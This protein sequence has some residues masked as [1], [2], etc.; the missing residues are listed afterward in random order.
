MKKSDW[1]WMPH[2]GHYILGD[3]CRF[4]L[5]TYVGGY[6]VSTIGELWQDQSSR[7]IHAQVHDDVYH[8]TWYKENQH[9]KGDYFDAAY[10]KQYG[11]GDLGAGERKYETMVFPAKK[12]S[13]GCCPWEMVSGSDVDFRGYEDAKDA[14][15]GHMELCK[16]WAA[17]HAKPKPLPGQIDIEEALNE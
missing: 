14:R 16:K 1:V 17:E 15:L 3:K 8:T 6:I 5:N 7:R 9:L 2:A 10:M 4:V 11:F 13:H 12:S